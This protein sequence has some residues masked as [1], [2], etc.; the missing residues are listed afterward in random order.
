M[1]AIRI[2]WL[3]LLVGLSLSLFVAS[4]NFVEDDSR[5]DNSANL[6]VFG[7]D[8]SP[9]EFGGLAQ[10]VDLN[11]ISYRSPLGAAHRIALTLGRRGLTR[12]Q[13]AYY[14]GLLFI[15]DDELKAFADA[16]MSGEGFRQSM[17]Y[18]CNLLLEGIHQYE[19]GEDALGLVSDESYPDRKWY[20]AEGI[21]LGQDLHEADHALFDRYRAATNSAV[22][23]QTCNL[24]IYLVENGLPFTGVLTAD[25]LVGNDFLELALGIRT[26]DDSRQPD[27]TLKAIPYGAYPIAGVLTDP[28]FLRLHPT[29]RTNV[30]RHRSWFVLRQF[31]DTDVLATNSRVNVEASILENPTM[32]APQCTVC[33]RIMDPVAGT[34][35]NWDSRGRYRPREWISSMRLPGLT[36]LFVLPEA[37]SGAALQWLARNMS[38]DP[39][40]ATSIVK[41][42]FHFI[43][44]N[45]VLGSTAP[46][47]ALFDAQQDFFRRTAL[48]FWAANYDFRVVLREIVASPFFLG[49]TSTAAVF[50]FGSRRVL[51][52][53]LLS[54]RTEAIFGRTWASSSGTDFLTDRNQYLQIMGGTSQRLRA[55]DTMNSTILSVLRRMANEIS[56]P[57]VSEDFARPPG[58]RQLFFE[59]NQDTLLSLG[60]VVRSTI[61]FL[62]QKV[63]GLTL[64]LGEIEN[65]Y[66]VLRQIQTAGQDAIAAG[67]ST[68]VDGYC[69]QFRDD[70][71]NDLPPDRV[72]F[73]DPEY[74]VR[75]WAAYLK[76]LLLRAEYFHE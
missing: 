51:T 16:M 19:R 43:T 31:M 40:F 3:G 67:M 53:E 33:H 22:M 6:T 29:T 10:F 26:Y 18:W 75:A 34:F 2:E 56:C 64:S 44:G 11:Q 12:E 32:D 45:D 9:D 60:P 71:G 52:P 24:M 46:D 25:Y 1:N 73:E 41:R 66:T 20:R 14:D 37:D 17:T 76:V 47:S 36:E 8:T 61:R 72:V 21:H 28:V 15:G 23:N 39:R 63:L 27:E 74:I 7:A 65:Q 38:D 59:V 69:R 5:S 54:A 48:L 50:N 62:N 49:S 4:C 35:K 30:N 58:S 13:I 42:F 68:R 57:I 55:L 70:L